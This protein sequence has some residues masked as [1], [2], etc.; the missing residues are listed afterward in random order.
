MKINKQFFISKKF[1]LQIF[2]PIISSIGLLL[3]LSLGLYY[4]YRGGSKTIIKVTVRT[5]NPQFGGVSPND[6]K[7]NFDPKIFNPNQY[8]E[9]WVKDN[10]QIIHKMVKYDLEYTKTYDD[11][12]DKTLGD[13]LHR[14]N[15]EE[16]GNMFHIKS[17]II[18]DYIV[19]FKNRNPKSQDDN[20]LPSK[21]QTN[22]A[23]AITSATNSKSKHNKAMPGQFNPYALA[24]K[25]PVG[26][27]MTNLEPN[28]IFNLINWPWK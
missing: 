4:K 27:S 19:N 14:W 13:F 12:K 2:L 3:G 18:G 17:S 6:S 22:Y 25:M 26:M 5:E 28:D 16:K 15:K 20:F 21:N 23:V 24:C 8:I 1:W 9:Y 7:F 10:T 11:D